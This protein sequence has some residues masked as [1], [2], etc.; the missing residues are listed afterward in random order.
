MRIM[1]IINQYFVKWI[2]VIEYS[3][4][5]QAVSVHVH[6][7]RLIKIEHIYYIS[8]TLWHVCINQSFSNACNLILQLIL[9]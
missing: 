4:I 8:T 9:R 5:L 2:P 6:V 7:N 1:E 3:D